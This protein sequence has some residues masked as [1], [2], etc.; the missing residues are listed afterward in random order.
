MIVLSLLSGGAPK[1]FYDYEFYYCVDSF[2]DQE[3]LFRIERI[4]L[5]IIFSNRPRLLKNSINPFGKRRGTPLT[6][7]R[8]YRNKKKEAD[9]GGFS[10]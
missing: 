4:S 5:Q 10:K 1:W 3:F 6:K 9:L 2:E 8:L 7:I